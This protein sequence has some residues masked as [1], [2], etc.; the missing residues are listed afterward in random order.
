MRTD[1]NSDTAAQP[2]R[3]I[4]GVA[5]APCSG[6][7]GG[8]SPRRGGAGPSGRT[9]R[10]RGRPAPRRRWWRPPAPFPRAP[11]PV[12]RRP[13]RDRRADRA[14]AGERGICWG[15]VEAS[16][17]GRRVEIPRTESGSL[18]GS[19]RRGFFAES[20][21][22]VPERRASAVVDSSSLPRSLPLRKHIP[23]EGDT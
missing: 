14:A 20:D 11:D 3:E 22:R 7:R 2:E 12:P 6:R 4:A 8:R 9:A 23:S 17:A 10:R 19:D 13:N 18:A 1:Q 15:R 16:P 21:W 5:C